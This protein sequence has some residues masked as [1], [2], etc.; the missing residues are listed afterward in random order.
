MDKKAFTLHETIRAEAEEI[1]CAEREKRAASARDD[2]S[3]FFAACDRRDY[4]IVRHRAAVEA[5]RRW[6][7]E[8]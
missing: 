4:A 8:R 2:S 6:R 5:L 1:A 7:G 3:A